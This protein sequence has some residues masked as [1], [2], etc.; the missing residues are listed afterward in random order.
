MKIIISLLIISLGICNCI[1]KGSY[2]KVKWSESTHS[3][4]EAPINLGELQYLSVYFSSCSR[5]N[6]VISLIGKVQSQDMLYGDVEF[7]TKES[8]IYICDAKGNIKKSIGATDIRGN[9]NLKAPIDKTL[10]LVFVNQED[11]TGIRYLVK[12]FK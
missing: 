4:E 9:F 11:N 7:L 8:L 1:Y 10:S 6:K 12:N 3:Y 5:K 2:S